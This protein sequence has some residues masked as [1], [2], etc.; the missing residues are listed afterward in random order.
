MYPAAIYRRFASNSR[1]LAAKLASPADKQALEL[2]AAGWDKAADKWEAT[3]SGSK[4]RRKPPVQ[5]SKTFDSGKAA[6]TVQ[7]SA[8]PIERSG[9]MTARHGVSGSV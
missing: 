8:I 1:R 5:L 9:R 4:K 2:M 3:L 7:A 6:R